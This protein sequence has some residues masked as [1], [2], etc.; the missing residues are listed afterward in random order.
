MLTLEA[1]FDNDKGNGANGSEDHKDRQLH[2]QSKES[3]VEEANGRSHRLHELE[4]RKS[5]H[6]IVDILAPEHGIDLGID[7]RIPE[8]QEECTD[9][10]HAGTGWIQVRY[11]GG[12][13]KRCTIRQ[14]DECHEVRSHVQHIAS[15]DNGIASIPCGLRGQNAKESTAKNFAG[16]NANAYKTNDLFGCG[17]YARSEA[18]C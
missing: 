2:I 8:A 14:I 18:N 13:F 4:E 17:S 1:P 15:N 3:G 7:A 10:R 12:I 16:T 6:S 11:I 5:T 9:Q